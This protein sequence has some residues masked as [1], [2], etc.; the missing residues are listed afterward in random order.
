MVVV[1]GPAGEVARDVD[2]VGDVDNSGAGGRKVAEDCK[3][4]GAVVAVVAGYEVVGG[5]KFE[6]VE[7]SWPVQ[8]DDFTVAVCV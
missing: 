7:L 2:H 6:G 1:A 8:V 3:V 5:G 4:A